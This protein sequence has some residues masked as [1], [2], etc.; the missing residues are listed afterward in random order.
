MSNLIKTGWL[1][2]ENNNKFAPKTLS[3]QVVT[4]DGTT[5]ENKIQAEFENHTHSWN[6]LTDKPFGEE[7]EVIPVIIDNNSGNSTEID[8]NLSDLNQ[9]LI[10]VVDGVEYKSS[11]W[12]NDAGEIYFGDSR[13]N[14]DDTYSSV[15]PEDVPFLIG[16]YSEDVEEG[17]EFLGEKYYLY[18]IGLADDNS[19][20]E[21]KIPT[22]EIQTK[23]IDENLIPDT[24]AR[25]ANLHK[26]AF[27]GSWNDLNDKPFGDVVEEIRK[28]LELDNGS[29]IENITVSEDSIGKS[30]YT[31]YNYGYIGKAP[32][33]FVEGN[34]YIVVYNGV[35][36]ECVSKPTVESVSNNGGSINSIGNESIIDSSLP[37]TG[38]PFY[39]H[40]YF[41]RGSY[42]DWYYVE[43]N[44][45]ETTEFT[46]SI[47]EIE[48]TKSVKQLDEKYI[49]KSISRVDHVHSWND[50]NDKPFGEEAVTEVVL[51]E[52]D[53]SFYNEI[54]RTADPI[55]PYQK[56]NSGY[57]Y[58]ITVDGVSYLCTAYRYLDAQN[59]ECICLGDSRL[60]G[61]Y[62]FEGNLIIDDSHSEDVPFHVAYA[63]SDDGAAGL[64]WFH[65]F[66][67]GYPDAETHTIKIEKLTDETYI[68]VL[69]EKYI[70]DTISRVDHVHSWNDLEDRPF[71][72]T[73]Q[74]GVELVPETTIENFDAYTSYDN[75]YLEVMPVDYCETFDLNK[76]YTVVWD[77]VIYDN[78]TCQDTL[79][80]AM[81]GSTQT[82]IAGAYGEHNEYPFGIIMQNI[83]G[84][85]ELCVYSED[86]QTH[87]VKVIDTAAEQIKHLDEEYIPDT[88]A[89]TE[90]IEQNFASKSDVENI[91]LSGYETKEDAQVKYD[92]LAKVTADKN[93]THTWDDLE[94]RPFYDNGT[95]YEVIERESGELIENLTMNMTYHSNFNSYTAEIGSRC[96]L[97]ED[98]DGISVIFDGL[99]YEFSKNDIKDDF[100]LS[101]EHYSYI[102]NRSIV[103]PSG[104]DTGEPFFI[105]YY[106]Y[107]ADCFY[108]VCTNLTDPTHTI[109]MYSI[110][111]DIGKLDEIYIPDTIARVEDLNSIEGGM[112][113]NYSELRNDVNNCETKEAA[114]TKYNE[115]KSYVDNAASTV[116]NDL[117]NGAGDAYDTLHE[118]GDLIDENKDAIDAL[119]EVA[120][121]KA[122]K[123]HTHAWDDLENRPFW[124][125][126]AVVSIVDEAT[127]NMDP[128]TGMSVVD[129]NSTPVIGEMYNVIYNGTEYKCLANIF[130]DGDTS[131]IILGNIG[132]ITGENPTEEPFALFVADSAGV[133]VSG[134]ETFTISITGKGKIYHKIATEYLPEFASNLRNGVVWEGSLRSIGSCEEGGSYVLG[135]HATAFGYDTKAPGNFS[136]AEGSH[137][138]TASGDS[139]HAEGS[140]TTASGDSSHAEGGC[141]TASGATSHA[142]GYQTDAIG[143][144]SHTEGYRTE[145][146]GESSHTEGK[147]TEAHGECQHVQGK[148]NIIDSSNKYAHIVGN[149]SSILSYQR[150]NAHTLDWDGNAW[151][152][153]TIKV[154]GSSY[155]D[156]YE[157][158]LKANLDLANKEI[159]N[160]KAILA[161]IGPLFE[162]Y[163]FISTDDI[164]E[165]C[166]SN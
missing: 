125:E 160:L 33:Q 120:T 155:D 30:Y 99:T 55:M 67:F 92:E 127:Y 154:G 98:L 144:F 66:Y 95:S 53:Q 90:Y 13:L 113:D 34:K 59:W 10:I 106:T 142:E 42:Q 143:N 91:D 101:D 27:T 151:Y 126:D 9:E 44:N 22:G 137:N 84:T 152:Q 65:E 70:P 117:L 165:I 163:Q 24:I 123:E 15:H 16:F 103:D 40:V 118:L 43:L 78:V 94:N 31:N 26:V 38:E 81:I 119:R 121:N 88:I 50:L 114:Q 96:P 1:Y 6:D 124:A 116:K 166:G 105:S 37:D 21:I 89:R 68:K 46:I 138:T 19:N 140:S 32:D 156:G 64:T 109:T 39:I 112:W 83:D 73:G 71:G 20:I 11:A 82:Q 122:N 135:E 56:I 58:I 74:F 54:E 8:I 153:G 35:E 3:S 85:P 108:T 107:R 139:S 130:D 93:H 115:I 7:Q 17:G 162:D 141:T 52:T 23:P 104:E 146:H 147:G 57:K 25:T 29:S 47:Y 129:I 133:L 158:A 69:D 2:D 111:Q 145:A 128:E 110:I 4:P 48:S 136:H 12:T 100:Q 148:Y 97:F 80:G 132:L 87:T 149:G 41:H 161:T 159:E 5:L 51:A 62:D 131:G 150:S 49:P 60:Y 14:S 164:N 75:V 72:K 45:A 61:N 86:N 134:D 18:T 36:Y 157:V 63:I 76:T 77:G 102:G 79:G 28:P